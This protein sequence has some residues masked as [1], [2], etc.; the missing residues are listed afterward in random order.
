MFRKL[1]ATAIIFLGLF[2]PFSY[3]KT[4]TRIEGPITSLTFGSYLRVWEADKE[5]VESDDSVNISNIEIGEDINLQYEYLLSESDYNNFVE[6]S[7]K[8][9]IWGY[10]FDTVK[11]IFTDHLTESKVI[12]G[13]GTGNYV[14][15]E[16]KDTS[17]IVF[18]T[19]TKGTYTL[20]GSDYTPLLEKGKYS[21]T[22]TPI[23]GYPISSSTSKPVLLAGN[24]DDFK[25]DTNWEP[26]YIK[27]NTDEFEPQVWFMGT[28]D[29]HPYWYKDDW[30]IN[31][32]YS[33]DGKTK[34]D[35]V[36]LMVSDRNDKSFNKAYNI[37]DEL[38]NKVVSGGRHSALKV[39]R[40]ELKDPSL[41]DRYAFDVY[42]EIDWSNTSGKHGTISTKN[43]NPSESTHTVKKITYVK[44][45]PIATLDSFSVEDNT[46]KYNYKGKVNSGDNVK[47]DKLSLH[48][49]NST[50]VSYDKVMFEESGKLLSTA[51]GIYELNDLADDFIKL[52]ETYKYYFEVENLNLGTYWA[53][54]KID[55]TSEEESFTINEDGTISIPW[56][57][58]EPSLPISTDWWSEHKRIVYII[59]TIVG[60]FILLVIVVVI[61]KK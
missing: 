32:Y 38:D 27:F 46:L 48:I 50:D 57:D 21:Y 1:M 17:K 53:G 6:F 60:V 12:W 35:E 41:Q 59:L 15:A 16:I 39:N 3:V 54:F 8:E 20:K 4:D 40:S 58:L 23:F 19:V 28:N 51:N 43:N 5:Y 33:L 7:N 26:I 37:T 52:D 49:E 2:I 31:F 45:D 18:N 42:V 47:A 10:N 29:H 36:R 34:A 44:Y 11:F 30:N 22:I 24:K 61:I 14:N 25:V 55:Y 13:E 9:P 56:T